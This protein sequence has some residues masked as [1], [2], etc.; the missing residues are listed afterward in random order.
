MSMP[1]S[2]PPPTGNAAIVFH[3]D[4]GLTKPEM[5]F[6]RAQLLAAVGNAL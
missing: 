3:P 5:T 1:W 4:T 6:S 2:R